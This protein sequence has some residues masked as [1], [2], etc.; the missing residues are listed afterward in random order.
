MIVYVAIGDVQP[1]LKIAGA[2]V[3]VRN[4]A[5]VAVLSI[6]NSGNAHGRLDGFLT[7]TDARGQAFD[8]VAANSP[9]LPGETRS[10]AL[11]LTK[12]GDTATPLQAQFPLTIKG[13]LE[14]GKGRSTELDQRFSQ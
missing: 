3:E 1:E 6:T 9:I 13:K 11:S 14:W 4:G 5:P 12:R 8:A 2:R 7:G 10:I